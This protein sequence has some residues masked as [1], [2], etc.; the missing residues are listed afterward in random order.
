MPSDF[1]G[2]DL[3][4]HFFV[5]NEV[6]ARA[7]RCEL[8]RLFSR[9]WLVGRGRRANSLED[10]IEFLLGHEIDLGPLGKIAGFVD[11]EPPIPNTAANADHREEEQ[12]TNDESAVQGA[13]VLAGR[14]PTIGVRSEPVHGH[15]PPDGHH[16]GFD[17]R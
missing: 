2:R 17:A 6:S 10:A 8:A 16:A 11:E 7:N 4:L 5:R 3:A 12:Q 14:V 9:E 15:A 1:L 13:R